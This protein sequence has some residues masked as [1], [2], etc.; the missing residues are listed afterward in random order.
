MRIRAGFLA[1]ALK[2]RSIAVQRIDFA[3]GDVTTL[4]AQAE[5]VAERLD[6]RA[7]TIDLT[8]DTTLV[9]LALTHTMA[10]HLTSGAANQQ[11]HP[12][13]AMIAFT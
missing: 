3:D 1:D 7:L 12:F 8:G 4:H 6:G 2:A 5:A 9:T 10:P 13:R 11:L